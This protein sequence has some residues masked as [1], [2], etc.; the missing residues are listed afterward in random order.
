MP[1]PDA[2]REFPGLVPLP[3][4][5]TPCEGPADV[6]DVV[7]GDSGT[8]GDDI[9]NPSSSAA[10][11]CYQRACGDSASTSPIVSS[12]RAAAQSTKT[13]RSRRAK[14]AVRPGQAP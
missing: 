1:P 10:K 9:E 13:L 6:E 3:R 14:G 2:G 7:R 12:P 4:S 5:V 11:H 8:C